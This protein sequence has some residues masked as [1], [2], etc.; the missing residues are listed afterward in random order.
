MKN[1]II[2]ILAAAV[3]SSALFSSCEDAK[4]PAID[5]LVYLN[6]A[7]SEKSLEVTMQEGVTVAH[8]TV[9]LAHAI[10]K[11]V[12]VHLKTDSDYLRTYNAQNESS[13]KEVD[14]A[15]V[16]FPESVVIKAGATSADPVGIEITSFETAGAQFAI[17]FTIASV[18]GEVEKSIESSRII[19]N[20]VKPLKQLVPAF[21]WYNGMS[22]GTPEEWNNLELPNYT[23]EWWCRISSPMGGSGFSINNQAIFNS[24]SEGTEMY[25]RFGDLV[26]T[27][28]GSYVYNFLQIKTMGAQFDTGDPAQGFGL[29]G[30]TW[31]HFALTYDAATGTSLLYKDGVQVNSLKTA[32]GKPMVITRFSMVSSGSQYF[33]DICEMCQVRFWKTTRSAN[34]IQKNMFS[35][36]DYHHPDLLL[37]LPMN[38]T[39]GSKLNDVTGNGH[40][41][42]IGS[43]YPG[44]PNHDTVDRKE[45]SFNK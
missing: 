26:Y 34:Q 19:L 22:T 29:L 1:R 4:A 6:E 7:S 11:D 3:L 21:R 17:P 45:Y 31:M 12:T 37:Y 40:D 16:K 13:I 42:E 36:V 30:N 32:A 24:G 14:A 9:R 15:N 2:A 18:D 28:G 43:L 5:N 33:Q 38:E 41:V 25:I 8:V 39:D 27:V 44:Y 23:L 10:S 20:L 35:E